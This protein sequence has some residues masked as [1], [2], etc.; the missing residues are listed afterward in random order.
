MDSAELPIRR[1]TFYQHGVARVEREGHVSGEAVQLGIRAD[2]LSQALK[3]LIVLD[4][5][6]GR[7]LG[8]DYAL[9]R[10]GG[11]DERGFALGSGT[12]LLDLMEALVGWKLRIEIA[13]R[14]APSEG[15]MTGLQYG[16]K[17]RRLKGATLLL[18]DERS[19]AVQ[20]VPAADVTQIVPLER[21][22]ADEL[23]RFVE[24][25]RRSDG[26]LRATVRLTPGEHE[27]AVSYLVPAPAWRLSYRVIA[28]TGAEAD[29]QANA[30]IAADA[31]LPAPCGTLVLQG[32]ALVNNEFDE[33]LEAVAVSLHAGQSLVPAR[34]LAP[35]QGWDAEPAPSVLPRIEAAGGTRAS[36]R[37]GVLIEGA[38]ASRSASRS[39]GPVAYEALAP[40]TIPRRASALV[41]ILQVRLAYQ[42]ELLFSE[43][44]HACHPA[45]TL[46]CRNDAGLLLEDAPVTVIENGN[47]RGEALLASTGKGEALYL[48]YALETA[49]EIRV[50]PERSSEILRLSLRE[51]VLYEESAEIRSYRYEVTNRG[52]ATQAL[53]IERGVSS[54]PGELFDSPEPVGKADGLYR[55]ELCCPP[56]RPAGFTVRSRERVC[57][58]HNLKDMRLHRFD[59]FLRTRG[60][61]PELRAALEA[62]RAE[63][64]LI[65]ENDEQIAA[66]ENRRAR[67]MSRQEH[68][69]MN[70]GAL[71]AIGDEGEVRLKM[72]R[73]LHAAEGTL[74]GIDQLV[75]ELTAENDRRVR[76]IGSLVP[77][78]GVA[79]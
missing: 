57:R 5:S 53:T 25:G 35:A 52:S 51:G 43:D 8:I 38:E 58:S 74:S 18:L 77:A 48:P 19:G 61:A 70:I 7:V 40:V 32:W 34:P 50:R 37:D 64:A 45:A 16:K 56:D 39:G 73:E 9:P 42:R 65:Q 46:R 44:R 17:H 1:L 10:S 27:L 47:Y 3:S 6:G 13:G 23:K 67:L 66:L 41:P 69:R 72:V 59:G 14:G 63:Y 11:D 49:V 62:L 29:G 76:S 78:G 24:A 12:S 22:I 54:L 71:E 20:A 36:A 75:G 68:L 15:R 55:W 26:V 2:D 31:S 33:D 21:P 4:R 60:L 79:G 30:A 28:E